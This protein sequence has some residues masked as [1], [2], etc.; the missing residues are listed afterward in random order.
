MRVL[1]LSQ[2]TSPLDQPGGGAAGGMNTYVL[3]SARALARR[4]V[5]VEMATA[6]DREADAGTIDVGDGI[7][8]HVLA[9]PGEG[10]GGHAQRFGAALATAAAERAPGAMAVPDV[11]HGHYWLSGIAGAVAASRWGVPLVQSAHT[12][13]RVK[14]AALAPGDAPEGPERIA[15]EDRLAH[16]AAALVAST[17][18]EADQL[19]RLCGADR[20][21]VHVV[22]PGVDATIYT[23][24]AA[25]PGERAA[26]RAELGVPGDAAVIAYVG[27]LQPLKSPETLLQL[28]IPLRGA[29]DEQRP[30]ALVLC[31][32]PSGR[33]VGEEARLR[34]FAAALPPG[35]TV[36]FV[37]P[38]PA[39]AL[40]RLYRSVDAVVVPS[41]SESFGL[42]A[43]EAQACG[44]PVVASR[45]GGLPR[46]LDDGRAGLLV[47]GHDPSVWADA[48]ARVLTDDALASLLSA[49]GPRHAAGFPWDRTAAGL[50]TAYAA[51]GP[52]LDVGFR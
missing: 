3:Q 9:V 25:D 16:E 27:R 20:A 45:V 41:R 51:A 37:P 26:M 14:N 2:H 39:A 19:V 38:R 7:R 10:D 4:G 24:D 17:A 21:R 30:L 11:V 34:A 29:L 43:L 50:L 42:V 52:A 6:V 28:G 23:R 18:G 1:L 12:L 22:E 8:L 46:A 48:V 44:V 40:A 35:V 31:G 49:A 13:A 47:D 15:A 33:A 5:A 32:S 36:R